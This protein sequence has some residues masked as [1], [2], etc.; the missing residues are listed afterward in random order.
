MG[1]Y[2]LCNFLFS[3]PLLS[4]PAKKKKMT[5]EK[6]PTAESKAILSEK[7]DTELVKGARN[8]DTHKGLSK[9]E[10]TKHLFTPTYIL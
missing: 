9:P 6:H 3:I 10:K 2:S 4:P 8:K 1:L 7:T 5:S